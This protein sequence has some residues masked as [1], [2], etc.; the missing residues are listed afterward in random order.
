[1][2][3]Q[4]L[5]QLA[6]PTLPVGAFAYSEGLEAA[7]A[8]GWIS[9]ADA[10]GDW[11][12]GILEH[13]FALVDAPVLF[14]LMSAWQQAGADAVQR[15]SRYLL[16]ARETAERRVQERHLGT[17]LATLL[18][19]LGLEAAGEWRNGQ[20][21]AADASF[22]ALFS[23]AAVSWGIDAED[24][25]TALAWSWL[26]NQV[27]AAV[28]LVPLGQSEGQR[29]LLMLSERVPALLAAARDLG[30]DALGGALPGVALM[31]TAHETLYSRLFRS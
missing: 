26:E 27:M 15:W 23:L 11:L 24:A 7:V 28:K 17:A 18:S 4:R 14:R 5:L 10:V 22:A 3:L 8:H 20:R 12:A 2:R 1:M 9:D 21:R 19:S 13:S 16:A 31:G 29:L 6:S 25:A 30:D